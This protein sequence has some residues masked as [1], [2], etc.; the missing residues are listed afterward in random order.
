MHKRDK[1]CIR[2]TSPDTTQ[3]RRLQRN[4]GGRTLALAKAKTRF[5]VNN[6]QLVN[7][8]AGFDQRDY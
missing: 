8:Y 7:R 1:R 5:G 2:D 6:Q 3:G 4:L